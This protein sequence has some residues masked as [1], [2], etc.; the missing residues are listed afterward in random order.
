MSN[1]SG[2]R[3][4]YERI[5]Y[6]VPLRGSQYP[7]GHPMLPQATA[8]DIYGLLGRMENAAKAHGIDTNCDDWFHVSAL[9]DD[10]LVFWF[11]LPKNT[12]WDNQ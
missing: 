5:E 2:G 3:R 1:V 4:V 9:E 7:D 8:R 10:K 12:R 11:D 6:S